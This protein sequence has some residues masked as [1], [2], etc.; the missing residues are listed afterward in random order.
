MKKKVLVITSALLTVSTSVVCAL[1]LKKN[2]SHI[3]SEA[4]ATTRTLTIDMTKYATNAS[5]STSV[6]TTLTF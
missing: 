5:G 3:D 2:N 1:T 4:A 6:K